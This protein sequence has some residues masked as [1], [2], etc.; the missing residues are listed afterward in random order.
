[1]AVNSGVKYTVCFAALFKIY[2]FVA[3]LLLHFIR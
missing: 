2:T 1:M 3:Q